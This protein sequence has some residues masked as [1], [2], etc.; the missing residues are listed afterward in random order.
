MDAERASGHAA[1]V[2]LD[3][4]ALARLCEALNA[5][6]AVQGREV[7]R[8]VLAKLGAVLPDGVGMTIDFDAAGAL[9]HPMVV[10]R[11][12]AQE[13][14]PTFAA[15]T[16]REQEVAGL[17]AVGLRN[18]DIGLALGIALGTVKDHVHRI[19]DKT[20]LDSRA[21]VAATWTKSGR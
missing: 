14:D 3:D 17:L 8:D 6:R 18:K 15:L 21:A 12:L 4:E 11:P 16:P 5:V 9:G 10:L 13:E 1:E 19:L 7:P 2:R 20:G